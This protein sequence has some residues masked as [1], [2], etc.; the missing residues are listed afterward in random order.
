MT[1][2]VVKNGEEPINLFGGEKDFQVIDMYKD[3]HEVVHILAERGAGLVVLNNKDGWEGQYQLVGN[4]KAV[5]AYRFEETMSRYSS[6]ST[7]SIIGGT[8]HRFVSSNNGVT[9][10]E[11]PI[12]DE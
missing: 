2:E 7:L 10:I 11:I 6:K 4:K 8:R 5:G 3:S 12:L 9:W 1:F